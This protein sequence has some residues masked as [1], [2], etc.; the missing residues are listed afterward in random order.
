[1]TTLQMVATAANDVE[2]ANCFY[3]DEC[4]AAK[5]AMVLAC[6]YAEWQVVAGF[7]LPVSNNFIQ[8]NTVTR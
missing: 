8:R 7:H 3:F 4:T 1:M 2:R 6:I 5:S